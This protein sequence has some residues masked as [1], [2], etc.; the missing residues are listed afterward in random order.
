MECRS[1]VKLKRAKC[2]ST[3]ANVVYDKDL[4]SQALKGNAKW[5]QETCMA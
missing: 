3:V 4:E 2:T 5:D 1:D